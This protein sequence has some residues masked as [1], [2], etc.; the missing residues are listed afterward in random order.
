MGF[1]SEPWA[2]RMAHYRATSSYYVTTRNVYPGYRP[3]Y[4]VPGLKENC[5]VSCA[6][7]KLR[8]TGYPRYP[9]T[10]CTSSGTENSTA[11]PEFCN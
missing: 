2:Q 4:R 10:P 1:F 5:N 3:Y 9:G 11:K 6:L 7:A 8:G